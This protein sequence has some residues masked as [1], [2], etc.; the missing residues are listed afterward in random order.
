M[1]K[2]LVLC[3][4][5]ALLS[6]CARKTEGNLRVLTVN[7]GDTSDYVKLSDVVSSSEYIPLETN[8]SIIIDD[9][10]KVI[11]HKET[12]YVADR[13]A[14]YKYDSEGRFQSKFDK[15]GI[16]PDEYIHLSDFYIGDKGDLWILSR[17]GKTLYN[18][19][20]KGSLKEAIQL[21]CWATKMY[22]IDE[23]HLLLY[24]GN[25]K[26]E[27]NY[28]Q[29]VVLNPRIRKI[30]ERYLPIDDKKSEYLHVMGRNYFLPINS[31]GNI[32]FYQMF[33]DTIYQVEKNSL[34]P[35]YY[36]NFG[37]RNIPASFFDNDYQN[38]MDFFQRLSPKGYA[39]GINW[40]C[41]NNEIFWLSYYY[42]GECYLSVLSGNGA[43]KNVY[44][45][46]DDLSLW[47]YP[48]KF[49]ELGVF[50]QSSDELIFA[51]SPVDIIEYGETNLDKEQQELLKQKIHYTGDDQNM[52]LLKMKL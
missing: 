16:A 26:S 49:R 38:I 40:F 43:S 5:L 25:E 44:A 11:S 20:W 37:D 29:L 52:V 48:I 51:L 46:V 23:E 31:E 10:V 34:I 41:G 14:I 27:D 19:D 22:P 12:L 6:S 33:N 7:M 8:D 13:F 45:L 2:I 17:G 50:P 47:G 28:C 36:V 18:Y 9:I 1:K 35:A 24:V 3:G 15:H 30:T 32:Y 21:N 42:Q 4:V 39:Y